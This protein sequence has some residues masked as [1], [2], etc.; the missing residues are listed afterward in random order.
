MISYA[1]MTT[2]LLLI[3]RHITFIFPVD[4]VSSSCAR[5]VENIGNHGL[6]ILSVVSSPDELIFGRFFSCYK[7]IH[8]VYSMF[9]CVVF[10]FLFD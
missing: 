3:T 4:S 8:S 7:V 6:P 1:R 2:D 5:S 9:S 10:M